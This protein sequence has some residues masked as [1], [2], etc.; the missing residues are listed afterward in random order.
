MKRFALS[1]VCLAA[2]VGLGSCGKN[3]LYIYN[4]AYY[5]P[6]DV[7]SDFEKQ[8]NVKI[9]Y[10]EFASNEEM[11]ATIRG[12]SN[13][14]DVIFPGYDYA[15]IMIRNDML[16][17][18]DKSKL[19]NLA[20][21]DPAISGKKKADPNNDYCVPY[22]MG[23]AGIMVNKEK[24]PNYEESWKIF[25]RKD[26][27]GKMTLLDDVREVMA[28]A[29]KTNGYSGNSTNPDEIAK[30]KQTVIGWK[31]NI[32][33]FD[34]ATFGRAFASGELWVVHCFAENVWLEVSE[35]QK[36]NEKYADKYVFFIPK[37]G[38]VSYMDT[39]AILKTAPHKDLAY[40]FINY[41]QDP[42]V[43]ARVAS[44]VRVPSVNVPARD[45]LTA[46]PNYTLDAVMGCELKE[47]LGDSRQLYSDAWKA[48][49][50][51]E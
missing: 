51:G 41:I 28:G 42:A 45:K 5:I 33:N 43:Y 16:E 47:D 11:Y 27:K 23:A 35:G 3:Q 1:L 40:K 20:N 14:Y 38:N 37:E 46:Q 17:K 7:L 8:N 4:W 6:T 36:D 24:I 32:L 31:D 29:L 50:G 18:L 21:V 25:D 44:F 12:G 22:F 9:E 26:L 2:L 30:A 15:S 13:K 48:I 39:M 34:S 49:R 19:P 10:K